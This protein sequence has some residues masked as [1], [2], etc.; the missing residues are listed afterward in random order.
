MES[1]KNNGAEQER[2]R[3]REREVEAGL[4]DEEE[5]EEEDSWE[6]EMPRRR[7]SSHP[8]YGL[9]VETHLNC[10]EVSLTMYILNYLKNTRFHL[11]ANR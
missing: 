1:G 11:K 4:Q 8:L 5:E 3:E 2:E 7:I 9:L 10:L 6:G